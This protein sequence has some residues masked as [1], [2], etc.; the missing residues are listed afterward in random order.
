MRKRTL[1]SVLAACAAAAALVTAF[2]AVE[3]SRIMA[4]AGCIGMPYG[5]PG[6]PV[7]ESA[8]G[9][10]AQTAPENCGDGK[11][12]FD[13]ECDL[14]RFN[15]LTNC[16][17]ECMLLYCGDGIVSSFTGEE[18]EP[19]VEEMYVK[20]E[21]GKLTTEKR[22]AE[23]TCGTICSAPECAADGRCS[24]GCTQEFRPSCPASAGRAARS[25]S[26]FPL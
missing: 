6:C 22:F 14:G 23:A 10:A 2:R 8:A 18:C 13:E 5:Y 19:E 26:S 16:T 15:G 12:D 9:A 3:R 20:D 1:L 24:G 11:R 21:D 25:Q 7:K 17:G 4:Q